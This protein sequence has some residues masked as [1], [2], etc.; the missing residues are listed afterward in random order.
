MAITYPGTLDSFTNPSGSNTQD[1]PDHAL[2][3]SNANDAIEA[4]ESTLGTT[5]GTSVL[6]DFSAGHFPA[7]VN[8]GGTIVQ[9]LTGG[10]IN[11]TVMG[12]SAITGGT[13][14][15]AVITGGTISGASITGSN[16]TRTIFIPANNWGTT[17]GAP[18]YASDSTDN[19]THWRLEPT[20]TGG[21]VSDFV[22]VPTDYS[23]GGSIAVTSHWAMMAGGTGAVTLQ[24]Q[25]AYLNNT[26]GTINDITDIG[27]AAVSIPGTAY[28]GTTTVHTAGVAGPTAAGNLMKFKFIRLGADGGDTATGTLAF[29]GMSISYTAVV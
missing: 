12:T 3:H 17:N 19:V 1:S 13:L 10:T 2:Q 8:S 6:K 22:Q 23:A 14:S 28:V 21:L 5:A 20:Q 16:R 18:V 27:A 15:G 26:S 25:Y 9:T 11:N 7:R 24:A 4:I 29:L